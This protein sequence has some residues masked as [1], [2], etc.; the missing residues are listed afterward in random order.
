MPRSTA[1]ASVKPNAGSETRRWSGI[2]MGWPVVAGIPRWYILRPQRDPDAREALDRPMAVC[3]AQRM[4]AVPGLLEQGRQGLRRLTGDVEP[5]DREALELS[6]GE[7]ALRGD[8]ARA[9]QRAEP[10]EARQ[11]HGPD[12]SADLE[13]VDRL[14][15]R[16]GRGVA[17]RG[18][19]FRRLRFDL[20]DPCAAAKQDDQDDDRHED[21]QAE[22]QA[23]GR[24]GG[25]RPSR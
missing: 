19:V 3:L 4:L 20:D 6:R 7:G 5:L 12:V 14:L 23:E 10:A 22:E 11:D 9:E 8:P 13:L 1:N 2:L 17:G 16:I 15:H 24:A 25:N 21:G 18:I